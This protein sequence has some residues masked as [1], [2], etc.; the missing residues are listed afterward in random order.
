MGR[1]Q[2]EATRIQAEFEALN[3]TSKIQFI[4]SDISLLKNVDKVCKE[5]QDKEEAVNLLFMSPGY[6]TMAGRTGKSQS[7]VTVPYTCVCFSIRPPC[8]M[9]CYCD[10]LAAIR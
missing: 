10:C 9:A 2:T 3:P 7:H 1:N 8:L 6:L 5:I 4:Q